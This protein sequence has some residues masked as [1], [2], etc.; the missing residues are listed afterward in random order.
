[1]SLV[2]NQINYLPSKNIIM[3]KVILSE[4]QAKLY[5]NYEERVIAFFKK[6]FFK[7]K[8]VSFIIF[9]LALF[10]IVPFV[11]LFLSFL[12][13]DAVRAFTITV[14]A[15]YYF[16]LSLFVDKSK[17]KLENQLIESF[18]PFFS[19]YEINFVDCSS[20]VCSIKKEELQ[21]IFKEEAKK[22]IERIDATIEEDIERIK[23]K[24][25]GIYK[26]DVLKKQKKEL[27]DIL[28]E[29]EK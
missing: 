5:S 21:N 14:S 25:E 22:E 6:K 12:F 23:E 16:L 2:I 8:I 1:V 27:E 15:I 19:D 7:R 10:I 4:I 29:L 18:S 11:S 20:F 3:E 28:S 9:T 24:G 26:H 17:D 13:P